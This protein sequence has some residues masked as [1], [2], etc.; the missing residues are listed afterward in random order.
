LGASVAIKVLNVD[1]LEHPAAIGQFLGEARLLTTLDHNNIVRWITFDRTPEG[2]HYFVMEFLRGQELSDVLT[3]EGKL[4][5]ADVIIILQQILSALAA[6]HNLPDGRS[7]LHLD[8]KPRNVFALHGG[9]RQVKVIDFGISQHVGAAART[10][11]ESGSANDGNAPVAD[12]RATMSTVH[13]DGS[14]GLTAK[15]VQRAVGGTPL[16]ASPEHCC[17]LRGDSDIVE[18]DGRSDLYSLGIMG[19]EMLS[20]RLPWNPKTI[21]EC[22]T[23]AIEKPLPSLA[24]AGAKVPTKL[25]RFLHK[26]AAKDREDRFADVREA[27]AELERIANPKRPVLAIVAGVLLV[28]A[29][30]VWQLWPDTPVPRIELRQQEVFVGPDAAHRTA[31][32]E[33]RN[34]LAASRGGAMRWV[35]DT[36]AQ[37][38]Q[39][40]ADWQL[41]LQEGA[42]T[43]TVLVTP[44]EHCA[45]VDEALVYLE[46]GGDT[47]Q[48]S[49]AMRVVYLP[50]DACQLAMPEIPGAGNRWV[51]P[52]GAQIEASLAQGKPDW[53]Q[54]VDVKFGDQVQ[55]ATFYDVQGSATYRAA[56]ADFKEPFVDTEEPATFA[57]IL[58]DKAGN[59]CI[60]EHQ[61]SLAATELTIAPQLLECGTSAADP[62]VYPGSR[63]L[64]RM[65]AN[66][67]VDAKITA[68]TDEGVAVDVQAELV[69][70]G[71]YRLTINGPATAYKG[72]LTVSA[73][74]ENRVYHPVETRRTASQTMRFRYEV[75][76]PALL[77][78]ATGNGELEDGGQI[79]TREAGMTFRL[80]RDNDVEL[81]VRVRCQLGEEL[82]HE[83]LVQLHRDKEQNT[84][85][86]PLSQDGRY[87]V[88]F[89]TYQHFAGSGAP[90]VDAPDAS[91][92]IAVLRDTESPTVTVVHA[93]PSL[94]SAELAKLATVRVDG[95]DRLAKL[96]CQLTGPEDEERR[97]ELPL[98][99]VAGS[100]AVAEAD[101][102]FAQL[103]IQAGQ[104][105]DGSYR[106]AFSAIDQAGN[107]GKAGDAN[108]VVANQGPALRLVSP[109]NNNRWDNVGDTFTLKVQA[110]D[111]NGVAAVECRLTTTS[112]E[113]T[114]WFALEL[115]A[116]G[117]A[118]SAEWRASRILPSKWSDQGVTISWRGKD[119]YDN[120][121]V[122]RLET[123]NKILPTFEAQVRALVWN[124]PP[125]GDAVPM[126]IVRGNANFTYGG[127]GKG[128]ERSSF[129]DVGLQLDDLGLRFV[130]RQED[131]ANFY[132]DENEVTV[133]RYLAFLRADD[134][135]QQAA[136]WRDAKPNANRRQQL[137][138]DLSNQGR[139]LPV[140]GL[141]WY[142]CA[143]YASWAG[144]R[145]PTAIEWE[146]A[147][148]GGLEYRVFS[149]AGPGFD[150]SRLAVGIAA[151]WPVDDGC[152]R[153]AS[154]VGEGLRNLCSNVSEWVSDNKTGGRYWAGA[155]FQD[156]DYHFSMLRSANAS[157]RPNHVGFR[158]A[159][160]TSTVRNLLEAGNSTRFAIDAPSP[161]TTKNK[162]L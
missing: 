117:N 50:Q 5:P 161:S 41:E 77:I 21:N 104:L 51:D 95:G 45:L 142:E 162:K 89:A 129:R 59:S 43:P 139:V 147:V 27:L 144:K 81:T 97:V 61:V 72:E 52:A 37:R 66:R 113:S 115:V 44:P 92:T 130:P 141:D 15:G 100:G 127:R 82:V 20:G 73:E 3:D 152:D 48:F 68:R 4:P 75:D 67:L 145:L 18:L 60:R 126:R 90:Q 151:P 17:H 29:L 6:A 69:A 107:E 121:K 103:G 158:C 156:G 122:E 30:L 22:F 12:L 101:V 8:L 149:A 64:L 63:P 40:L 125:A 34:L 150:R 76:R 135:Y 86:I 119:A 10:A 140:T 70:E 106:L 28:A 36:T 74:E 91:P 79:V 154:R 88:T 148:R 65:H 112:G 2:M 118:R 38:Q 84:D 131:V 78:S 120:P 57:V 39:L 93:P 116:N 87:L 25:E 13:H 53:V 1:M 9:D 31:V 159:I 54:R 102:S 110:D 96:V 7:L 109:S 46:I 105:A 85:V 124:T 108:F 136:H 62:L 99:V 98:S 128:S 157:D 114:D 143:A 32:I 47:P 160:D 11:P 35:N 80:R 153:V 33:V 123:V 155:S 146:Y 137:L 83:Q 58:T 94:V 16:Y 23:V 56:F 42:G 132:L 134:G 19:F 24:S 49:G 111:E 55:P 26:C 138:K 133:A 14:A 71:D